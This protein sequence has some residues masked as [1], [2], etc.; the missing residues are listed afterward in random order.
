MR[1]D[2]AQDDPLPALNVRTIPSAITWWA[3]RAGPVRRATPPTVRSPNSA[4]HGASMLL[5]MLEI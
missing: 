2:R 1:P 5:L 4:K 3:G